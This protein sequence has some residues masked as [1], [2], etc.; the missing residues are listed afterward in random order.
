MRLSEKTIEINFC[1]QLPYILNRPVFWFGLTQA[2]EARLGF[3]TCTRM[4]NGRLLIFQFKASDY[5]LRNGFRRFN[6]DHDQMVNLKRQ[7]RNISRS[8]FYVLPT[9]GNTLELSN[10]RFDLI[11]NTTLLDVAD[12]PD[13]IPPALTKQGRPRAN[14]NHYIDVRYPIAF[15]RSEPVRVALQPTSEFFHRSMNLEELIFGDAGIGC[16]FSQ[17]FENVDE[18]QDSNIS[19]ST[20]SRV[21]QFVSFTKLLVKPSAALFIPN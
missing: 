20:N 4:G 10:V 7:S 18:S 3:D 11:N 6:A 12:L 5:V 19:K 2:Q 16:T 1:T 17:L 8:V 9:I 13:P 21:E 14:N 15:L